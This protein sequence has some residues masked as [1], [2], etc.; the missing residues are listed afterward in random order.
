MLPVYCARA[1][2]G[3]S[4]RRIGPERRR[5]TAPQVGL[6]FLAVALMGATTVCGEGAHVACRAGVSGRCAQGGGGGGRSYSEA[7]A[8]A[9]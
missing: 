9:R 2:R 7:G 5:R 3:L 8:V 6:R 4:G 1:R